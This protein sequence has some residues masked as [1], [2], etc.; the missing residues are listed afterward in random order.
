MEI[1]RYDSFREFHWEMWNALYPIGKWTHFSVQ[2]LHSTQVRNNSVRQTRS[3]IQGFRL[4]TLSS[5]DL[6]GVLRVY[7]LQRSVHSVW[8]C[9]AILYQLRKC[10]STPPIV[11]NLWLFTAHFSRSW[12]VA[13]YLL[14]STE[15]IQFTRKTCRW[16]SAADST[17]H[18]PSSMVRPLV[19]LVVSQHMS[20]PHNRIVLFHTTES[21]H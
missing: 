14:L 20:F 8:A 11:C 10:D 4:S 2:Q 15:Y 17:R 21:L 19:A 9:C 12:P 3:H 6:S 16:I 7:L 1:S 5:R 18:V 13:V